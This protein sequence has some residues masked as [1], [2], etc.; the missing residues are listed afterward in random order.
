[1]VY[2]I[3]IADDDVMS[4]KVMTLVLTNSD[5]LMCSVV[6]AENGNSAWEIVQSEQPDLV[7]LDWEMPDIS[8]MEVLQKIK[9]SKYSNIPVII[10]TGKLDGQTLSLAL[11]NGATDYI[12][13]PIDKFEL[14]ART[15]SALTLHDR[16]LEIEN[17]NIRIQNQLDDL[18]RLSLIVKKTDNSVLIFNPDGEIEWANEGF[19]KMYGYTFEEFTTRY[20]TNISSLSYNHLINVKLAELFEHKHSVNYTTQCRV[21]YGATKWIQTT[22]TPIFDG[23]RIEKFIAIETDISQ[24]K[25]TEL[26]L[27]KR[28]EETRQLMQ[29]VQEANKKLEAQQTEIIQK[30]HII[31]EERR[32]TDNLLLNILPHYVVAQLKTIGHAMPR[33][34]KMATIMFTDFKGFTKSCE[35]LTPNEIVDALHF[36]FSK[37]DEIIESH[38]IEKIKTIGDAYMCVGGIPLRNH[39]NPFDVVLAGLEIKQF[40]SQYKKLNPDLVLPDWQLRIG[41]HTGALVAGVVGKIKFA[42]DTWGDSVNIANRMES[43]DEPGC[44]N[45]SAATYRYICNYFECRHRG[46]I[47]IKNHSAIDMYFVDRLKPQFSQDEDGVFPNER[48]KNILNEIC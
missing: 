45:I 6:E 40:M 35:N 47:D 17:Q 9:K 21:K 4:R 28:N 37:F 29:S 13:K 2:N 31:E 27:V 43:A 3:L 34:Y 44:I 30:N 14:I 46:A 7:L 19:T 11:D 12:K 1:M 10:V 15:K 20:G 8:G 23:N 48:F 5:K 26:E 36:F 42:Y 39:S 41:I 18:N 25:R 33:N 38:Y 24:Q 16:I 32:K 22:L